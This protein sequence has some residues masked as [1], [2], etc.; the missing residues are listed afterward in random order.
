MPT[1]QIVDNKGKTYFGICGVIL[2][3]FVAPQTGWMI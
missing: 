2:E 3:A 1:T